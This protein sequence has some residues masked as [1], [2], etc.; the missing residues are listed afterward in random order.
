MMEANRARPDG[1]QTHL[2][3]PITEQGFPGFLFDKSGFPWLGVLLASPIIGL[4]YWC[5]D[6]YIVQRVL[7]AKGL[8]HARRGAIFA[9]YLKLF[10]VF[11]FLLPGMVY[12]AMGQQGQLDLG[13]CDP[14]LGEGRNCDSVFAVLVGELLPDGLRGMVIAG[15]LAALM[16]SLASLFNSSATLFTVDFY[17][18][19]RPQSTEPHLVTVGRIATAAVVV[20]GI[21]WIPV[22]SS[23]ADYLYQYLQVVQSLIAPAIAAV[24]MMGIFSRSMT[25]KSGLI[26]LVAGFVL[27]MTRLGLLIARDNFGVELTGPFAVMADI[28]WLYFC[29]LL[30]VFTCLLMVVVS[31]VTAKPTSEQLVGLTYGSITPEQKA[32][33][34]ASYNTMD[35]VHSVIVVGIIVAVYIYFW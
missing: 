2:W 27:G 25:P 31:M 24:F 17:K 11:I 7:S 16:S 29:F 19:W 23:I 32:E 3:R 28:N 21:V 34:K 20:L 6:Q 1:D 26:G 13:A 33:V 14:A 15:L 10:P 4:W 9:G 30:F 8:A 22:M 5:T 12:I 18:K 35:I